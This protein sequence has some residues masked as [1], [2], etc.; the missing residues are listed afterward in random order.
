[1]KKVTALYISLLTVTII[2][3]ASCTTQST[4]NGLWE[5][6]KN[7]GTIEFKATGEVIIV[8]NMSATV[9]GYYKIEDDDL[10]KFELTASDILRD[11]VQPTPKTVIT[12]KIIRVSGD[13]LQLRIDRED[14]VENYRRIR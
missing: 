13:E 7:S 4:I 14:G 9:T 3:L 12:A 11:S 6:T 5:S 2:I 1:M 10:I 8:D